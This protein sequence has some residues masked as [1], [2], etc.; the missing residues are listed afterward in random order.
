[1]RYGVKALSESD[2][3]GKRGAPTR[4]AGFR[5]MGEDWATG[6]RTGFS[7]ELVHNSRVRGLTESPSEM[8][9]KSP[10]NPVT[11]LGAGRM[12]PDIFYGTPCVKG[13]SGRASEILRCGRRPR[14]EGGH[15][16]SVSTA[17]AKVFRGS[18]SNLSLQRR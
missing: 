4:L 1:M 17:F 2:S 12:R 18:M 16:F 10:L 15:Q 3:M 5:P 11:R 9:S 6:L 13:P 8:H 7:R 14:F